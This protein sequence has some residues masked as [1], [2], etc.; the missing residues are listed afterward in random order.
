MKLFYLSIIVTTSEL[1]A[2]YRYDFTAIFY[3]MAMKDYA[4]S[5]PV[6]EHYAVSVICCGALSLIEGG[7]KSF[8]YR[9]HRGNCLLSKSEV[10]L[11]ENKG[12][13]KRAEGVRHYSRKKSR[14][15]KPHCCAEYKLFHNLDKLSNGE[16]PIYIYPPVAR[17]L[18]CMNTNS[19]GLK[20]YITFKYP[21]TNEVVYKNGNPNKYPTWNKEGVAIYRKI[22]IDI[23]QMTVNVSDT[24]FAT[25]LSGKSLQPY[26]TVGGCDE[27]AISHYDFRGTGFAFHYSIKMIRTSKTIGTVVRGLPFRYLKAGIIGCQE[28]PPDFGCCFTGVKEP[29]KLGIVK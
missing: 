2:C 1:V 13:Y 5:G 10:D 26:A 12:S 17:V 25:L 20:E 14:K 3:P 18:Y 28:R 27:M 19:S 6:L 21:N 29:M 22:R 15:D 9:R 16:Y 8:D 11:C 23:N 24:T 7:F 4:I